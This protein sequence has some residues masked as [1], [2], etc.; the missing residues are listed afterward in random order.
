MPAIPHRERRFTLA[1]Y[2]DPKIFSECYII[3]LNIYI[4][5]AISKVNFKLMA[6]EVLDEKSDLYSYII[7]LT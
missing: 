5:F 6:M 7:D 1:L 4:I 2:S 3:I